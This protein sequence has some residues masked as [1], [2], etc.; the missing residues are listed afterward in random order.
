[1]NLAIFVPKVNKTGVFSALSKTDS[2]TAVLHWFEY[3]VPA[4]NWYY[5]RKN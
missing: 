1:M 3:G 5:G 2:G 4:R